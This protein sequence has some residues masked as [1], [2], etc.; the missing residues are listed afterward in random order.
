MDITP[1]GFR[2]LISPTPQ[3]KPAGDFRLSGVLGVLRRRN[4]Q[5]PAP[6]ADAAATDGARPGDVAEAPKPEAKA[7]DK[8]DGEAPAAASVAAP[9]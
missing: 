9:G 4:A 7:A 2:E 3:G 8:A 6:P 1:S 5:P